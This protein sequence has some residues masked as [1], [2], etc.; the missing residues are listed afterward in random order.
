MPPSWC[1][2]PPGPRFCVHC[3]CV[4]FILPSPPLRCINALAE[5][6]VA[7]VIIIIIA[8][9]ILTIPVLIITLFPYVNDRV[10]K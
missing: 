2:V 1:T 6:V 4:S 10:L 8:V 3:L 5:Q 9:T 7:I